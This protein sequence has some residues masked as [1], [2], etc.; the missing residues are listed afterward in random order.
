MLEGCGSLDSKINKLVLEGVELGKY[1]EALDIVEVHLRARIEE[2]R[3]IEEAYTT[4][5]PPELEAGELAP[6]YETEVADSVL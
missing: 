5:A 1:L 6:D 3:K 4:S 2:L